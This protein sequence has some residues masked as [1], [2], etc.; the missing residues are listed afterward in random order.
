MVSIWAKILLI[1]VDVGEAALGSF[2]TDDWDTVGV[3]SSDLLGLFLTLFYTG[4]IVI[5]N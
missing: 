4:L 2:F 3:L 1:F 5:K